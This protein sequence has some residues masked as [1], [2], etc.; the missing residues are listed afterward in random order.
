MNNQ[1]EFPSDPP[2]GEG[3]DTSF[4]NLW[5]VLFAPF[6]FSFAYELTQN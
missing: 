2:P 3:A 6:F 1:Y 5:L 4:E